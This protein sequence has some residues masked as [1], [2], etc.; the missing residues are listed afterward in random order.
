MALYRLFSLSIPKSL[1]EDV[2]VGADPLAHM[3]SQ[4]ILDGNLMKKKRDDKKSLLVS[5]FV[6]L[7]SFL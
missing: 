1:P 5:L 2:S 6:S 7:P 4:I 3:A